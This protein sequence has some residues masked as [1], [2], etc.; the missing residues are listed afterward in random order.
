MYIPKKYGKSKVDTCP[1]CEEQATTLNKQG[2][3]V[4]RNHVHAVLGDMKCVC[5]NY[6][7]LKTGKF[8]AFF[9]CI[10]CGAMNTK[11]VFEVN[12]VVDVSGDVEKYSNKK[13]PRSSSTK[14]YSPKRDY[15]N[16]NRKEKNK[17]PKEITIRSDDPI[18]FS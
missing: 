8:G 11:K 14:R 12:H 6:L 15:G 7:E 13:T 9:V 4:C 16:N 5:K 18:Y 1:F 10:S 2:L 3:T 17:S